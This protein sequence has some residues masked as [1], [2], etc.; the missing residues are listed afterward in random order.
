MAEDLRKAD[1]VTRSTLRRTALS[2]ADS[3]YSVLRRAASAYLRADPPPTGR[4]VQHVH[5]GL[6][7][8]T[9]A[10]TDRSA[11]ERVLPNHTPLL[12][13][14]ADHVTPDDPAKEA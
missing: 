4:A 1:G 13:P 14:P 9:D 5:E 7:A 6:E 2:L 3:R 10:Q 11:G 12:L 8:L